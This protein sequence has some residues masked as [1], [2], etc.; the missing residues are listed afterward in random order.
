[1][2]DEHAPPS[3]SVDGPPVAGDDQTQPVQRSPQAQPIGP[4]PPRAQPIGPPT[5]H[6]RPIGP[7]VPASSGEPEQPGLRDRIWS[8]R[9]VA[10][11]AITAVA[12]SG[13]GGAALA[14]VS[15]SGNDDRGGFG[16][17]GFGR[18][19]GMNGQ[20]PGQVPGQVNGQVPGRVNGQVPGG[21]N[22]QF[23]A[24]PRTN[25]VPGQQPSAAPESTTRGRTT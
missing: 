7:P 2:S 21:V 10:A 25:V 8:L 1:M 6:P 23:P 5:P 4:P 13:V 22:Q 14:S 3:A 17:G 9:T 19:G 18:P 20:V 12:L 24:R 16:R 15:N 11:A